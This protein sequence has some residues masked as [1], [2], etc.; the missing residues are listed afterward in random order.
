[1]TNTETICAIATAAGKGAIAVIRLSGSR[2]I[3]ITDSLFRSNKAGKKL[4]DQRGYSLHFGSIMM[5]DAVL[6]EVVVSL[7]KGPNSYTGEDVVEISCHASSYIQQNM[8]RLLIER[9]A[10]LAK[11]GEFTMRAY[12]NGKMDLSQA[13]SVA[14]LIASQ[15]AAAHRLALSQMRGGYSNEL[16]FLREQLL[17]FVSLIELELDFSEEDVE[18]ADRS[19]LAV[20]CSTIHTHL[21]KLIDSFAVGNAIKNG[22]PVAIV[23]RPNVGKSTLLNALLNEDRAIVSDIPGTTRDVIED[24]MVIGGVQ[25]RFIDT[26]GIRSTEDAVE[27]IGIRKTFERIAQAQVVLLLLD[28]GED[29]ASH[30]ASFD[31]IAPS[32]L[33]HQQVFMILNKIDGLSHAA[34]NDIVSQLTASERV[35]AGQVIGIASKTNSGIDDLRSAL[36]AGVSLVDQSDVIVSNARHHEALVHAC[37][38]IVRVEE[39]LQC[40]L[41]NDLLS[42]EIRQVLHYVGEITGSISHD[43]MLGYIFANFCIGK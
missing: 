43:E 19:E 9:G 28:G 29:V 11:P 20:L 38:A 2:A 10:S 6:D 35:P 25:F 13:E 26:A 14:D 40:G 12:M 3:E 30:L 16:R 15:S 21:T 33:P 5:N 1:M 34:C 17:R 23:G 31:E 39:G 37:D 8:L 24:S 4:I 18:F 7:Y 41:S 36:L 22:V 32:L 27:S 42:L